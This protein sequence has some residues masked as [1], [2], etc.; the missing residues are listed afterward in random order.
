MESHLFHQ[1][2]QDQICFVFFQ[3]F[4]LKLLHKIIM[5]LK[6]WGLDNIVIEKLVQL[7]CQFEYLQFI[8]K[9]IKLRQFCTQNQTLLCE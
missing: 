5:A 4:P 3:L 1:R 7:R 2:K 8:P 9:V 6:V